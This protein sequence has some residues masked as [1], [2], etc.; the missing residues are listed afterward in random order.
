M[1]DWYVYRSISQRE[2]ARRRRRI[3]ET[4]A[5]WLAAFAVSIGLWAGVAWVL[6]EGQP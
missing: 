5:W 3:A 6:T 4:V 2:R 1:S